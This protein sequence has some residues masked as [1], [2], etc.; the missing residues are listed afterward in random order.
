[1]QHERHH[2]LQPLD[3][4]RFGLNAENGKT[5]SQCVQRRQLIVAFYLANAKEVN[6][7]YDCGQ[8]QGRG[9][10]HRKFS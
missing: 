4:R 6:A 5:S 3:N 2:E 10:R 9:F 1:L 8:G 7:D